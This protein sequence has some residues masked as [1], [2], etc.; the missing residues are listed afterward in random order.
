M[1]NYVNG[2]QVWTSEIIF[3]FKEVSGYLTNQKR[4]LIIRHRF[5]DLNIMWLSKNK[6]IKILVLYKE[7]MMNEYIKI[8][9]NYGSR[10]LLFT[11]K[12]TLKNK[13]IKCY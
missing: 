6:Q 5:V 10:D 12:L 7:W 3:N 9:T 11:K 13:I 8:S 1:F 4:I 2:L